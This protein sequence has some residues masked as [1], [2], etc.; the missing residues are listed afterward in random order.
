MTFLHIV[1]TRKKGHRREPIYGFPW[2]C[3]VVFDFFSPH[4]V[5]SITPKYPT[6][7]LK[8]INILRQ[9]QTEIR[10]IK[11]S[12]YFITRT[13]SLCLSKLVLNSTSY[14]T[15]HLRTEIELTF[16]ELKLD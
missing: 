9:L 1:S 13:D 5:L 11:A 10:M 7:C 14:T 15:R 12:A 16:Q 6:V 8:N 3:L 4:L 2:T